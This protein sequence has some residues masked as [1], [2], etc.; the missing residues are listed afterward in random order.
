MQIESPNFPRRKWAENYQYALGN[1]SY[2]RTIQPVDNLGAND[3]QTLLGADLRN[4][5]LTST[6][7]ESIIGKL[8]RQKFKPSVSMIDAFS[9]DAR[10][11]VEAKMKVAMMLK[12]QGAEMGQYLG[13]SDPE[14][15]MRAVQAMLGMTKLVVAEL[16]AA[17][18]GD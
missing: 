15:S 7:L 10:T 13:G 9:M 6:I 3:S 17:Y 16:K 14:G 8:N 11:E 18:E 1:Q 4:M 12:Q 5:K 2:L